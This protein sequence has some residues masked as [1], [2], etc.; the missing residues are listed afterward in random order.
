MQPSKATSA[1]SLESKVFK[2]LKGIGV[3]QSSYHGGSLNGKDIKKIM[4]NA[5]YLFDKF[6]ALSKSGKQDDCKLEDD[7]IDAL[8]AHFKLVFVL[9]D[10]AFALAWK[11]NPTM[12]NSHQYQQSVK[13]AVMGNVNLGLT[14]T[15]KVH[16][17]FK[18]VRWQM[19]NIKGGLGNKMEDW[20][21]ELH[22][23]SK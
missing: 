19:D 8:C 2:I 3:E 20:I 12:D 7:D 4:S 9:W 6:S 18:H 11:K 5:T 22:Q 15:P 17:M 10:G 21:E 13:A 14:I 1:N 16:L 23:V